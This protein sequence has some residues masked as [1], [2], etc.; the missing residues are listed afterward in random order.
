MEEMIYQ[1]KKT[2]SRYKS[3]KEKE[4]HFNVLNK[5]YLFQE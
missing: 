4:G 5:T 3:G 2:R 1:F